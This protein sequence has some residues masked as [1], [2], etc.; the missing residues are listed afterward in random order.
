MQFLKVVYTNRTSLT[1]SEFVLQFFIMKMSERLIFLK[2]NNLFLFFFIALNVEVS[3]C[4]SR[5]VLIK[6]I[7]P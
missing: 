1:M 7:D 4:V 5:S 3:G 2:I 6:N